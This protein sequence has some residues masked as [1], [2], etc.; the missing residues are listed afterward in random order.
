MV[1]GQTPDKPFDIDGLYEM[2]GKADVAELLQMSVEEARGLLDQIGRAVAD[3]DTKVVMTAAHQ[4]KG[5]ASTMTIN[6]M[7]KLSFELET[8]ARQ[9]QWDAIPETKQ[10][11]EN[12]FQHVAQYVAE[13]LA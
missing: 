8:R 4:L 1:D 2:Y 13:V 5:L 11:L 6:Q 9:E 7:A 12:E 10:E 3:R